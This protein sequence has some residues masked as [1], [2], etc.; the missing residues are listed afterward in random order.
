M[1]EFRWKIKG[2]EVWHKFS[3]SALR[4]LC[5]VRGITRGKYDT[6]RPSDWAEYLKKVC[7]ANIKPIEA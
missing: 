6:Q 7:K 5:V 2:Y 3:D 1:P 4:E